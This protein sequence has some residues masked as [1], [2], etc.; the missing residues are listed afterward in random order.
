MAEAHASIPTYRSR[1][2]FPAA[3]GGQ[4][5][6]HRDHLRDRPRLHRHVLPLAPTL[7]WPVAGRCHAPGGRRARERAPAERSHVSP[8]GTSRIGI[9]REGAWIPATRDPDA[10]IGRSGDRLQGRPRLG[11]SLCRSQDRDLSSEGPDGR[12]PG[13]RGSIDADRIGTQTPAVPSQRDDTARQGEPIQV[14]GAEP[15]TAG[16]APRGRAG[17]IV[18]ERATVQVDRQDRRKLAP[19]PSAL[20]FRPDRDQSMSGWNRFRPRAC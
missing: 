9:G 18:V 11:R 10:R 7:R 20:D 13:P 4:R 19:W 15:A 3:G 16:A 2:R 5:N 6:R 17:G 8:A 12:G 14:P 1:D